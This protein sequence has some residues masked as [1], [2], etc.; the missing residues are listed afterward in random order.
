VELHEPLLPVI[1]CGD[2]ALLLPTRLLMAAVGGER[3]ERKRLC[4]D[5]GICRE[6]ARVSSGAVLFI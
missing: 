4:G 6:A 2:G 3:E 1:A 5:W